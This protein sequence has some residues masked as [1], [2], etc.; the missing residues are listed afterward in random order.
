MVP[1]VIRNGKISYLSAFVTLSEVFNETE[2][3]IVSRIKE[4]LKKMLPSYMIPR[5][6]KIK[7]SFPTNTNGKIDRRALLGGEM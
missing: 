4:D 7:D 3:K 6:I 2:F 1:P 5:Q